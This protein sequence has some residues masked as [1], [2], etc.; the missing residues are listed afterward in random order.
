[1]SDWRVPDTA[2]Q[3]YPFNSLATLLAEVC[4]DGV[5]APHGEVLHG[6]SADADDGSRFDVAAGGFF[7]CKFERT[8]YDIRVFNPFAQSNLYPSHKATYRRQEWEKRRKCEDRVVQVERS[9]F[10]Y[11]L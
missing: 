11:L 8:F 3:C 10:F 7:G 4:C 2:S 5:P 6:A 9:S 1:M